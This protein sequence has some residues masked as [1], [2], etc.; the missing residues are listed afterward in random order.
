MSEPL[1]LGIAGLGTVGI[2]VLNL[3]DDNADVLSR[4]CS[5]PLQVTAVSARDRNRDRGVDLGSLHWFD[6]CVDLARSPDIDIFV[7]L[8]G[9][10][11][12]PAKLAVEAA[13]EA[14]HHVVTANKAL[15]A[16]HGTELARLAEA[17]G[18]ALNYEAA[19]AGGIPI[20][21]TMRE[22]FAG[23]RAEMIYGILNG[24]CN[25]ILTHMEREGREFSD[26]LKDAQEL[27]YAEADPTFDVGG[28][29]AAHKLAILTSLAFGT[30]VNF[31]AIYVEGID[32]ITATD[33]QIAGE[34]GYRIKLLG[35]ALE[36]ETGIEQRVHPTLVPVNSP[37][38]QV[39]GVFNAVA[40]EG[41]FL[42]SLMIEGK[43]AGAGPTAS[44]VVAD[45]V[46]IAR[47]VVLPPLGRPCD[48]LKP[49]ERARMRAHHGGYYVALDVRDR[50]GAFAAIA[51]RMA[52]ENISLKSIVQR[53]AEIDVEI[54]EKSGTDGSETRLVVLITHDTLEKS[55]RDALAKIEADGD[56]T[57][58]PRM[59]RIEQL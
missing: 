56:I 26:V 20:V 57:Q 35:V 41:D 55:I 34:L 53:G 38:A 39:D 16:A 24:T 11:D 17:N 30:E 3:L 27:G 37:I 19:I 14:G 31:D 13:L 43:G 44:S 7:E 50:P 4:R 25:Y 45:I 28:F 40:V 22:S 36:T 54:G 49:Y 42:G 18:A 10:D 59:I 9:G 29:D 48:Q 8:I 46:D 47:G 51:Q 15:L 12:G 21:K 32:R 52:E 23:N 6:D 58:A 2:G 5:R 33:I 1:K